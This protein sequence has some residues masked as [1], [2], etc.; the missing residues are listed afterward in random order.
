MHCWMAQGRPG[1]VNDAADHGSR[2]ALAAA[3]RGGS[4]RPGG[5]PGNVKAPSK[6]GG[7]P[8]RSQDREE[9][10]K[11]PARARAAPVLARGSGFPAGPTDGLPC[12][13]KR[14][15]QPMVVRRGWPAA[16]PKLSHSCPCPPPAPAALPAGS[17]SLHPP[18]TRPVCLSHPITS[19]CH[20]M[21]AASCPGPHGVAPAGCPS[22]G[23]CHPSGT[24]GSQYLLGARETLHRVQR[25]STRC[26]T[27]VQHAA[28]QPRISA[29]SPLTSAARCRRQRPTPAHTPL[30]GCMAGPAAA[31]TWP[32]QA[33]GAAHA[34][35]QCTAPPAGWARLP[36]RDI[37]PPL[38]RPSPLAVPA[39]RP[40]HRPE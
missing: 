20:C 18:D 25:C 24:K 26:A 14:S 10:G 37:T 40:R 38:P 31:C 6:P 21:Q 9:G 12:P 3:G 34:G 5:L 22:R 15:L 1:A 36:P 33:Q 11:S 17:K 4:P 35:G 8:G 32:A 23:G 28:P 16:A 7:H 19:A 30:P 2:C 39:S 29:A 27:R 13:F